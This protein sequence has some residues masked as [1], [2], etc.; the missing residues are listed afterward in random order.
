MKYVDEATRNLVHEQR[1]EALEEDN[2]L[3]KNKIEDLLAGEDEAYL[4]EEELL[5]KKQKKQQ[6]VI[7]AHEIP[8]NIEI[9]IIP[10]KRRKNKK[11]SGQKKLVFARKTL[12]QILMEEVKLS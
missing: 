7:K 9:P 6:K 11:S 5:P 4:S 2:F 3:A 8:E 1:L 12:E 10:R